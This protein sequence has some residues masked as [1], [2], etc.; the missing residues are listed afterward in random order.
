MYWYDMMERGIVLD[1]GHGGVSRVAELECPS[2]TI[3][4]F[5]AECCRAQD[6]SSETDPA[7]PTERGDKTPGQV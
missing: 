4:A 2:V 3:C 5:D 7:M 1:H 6:C